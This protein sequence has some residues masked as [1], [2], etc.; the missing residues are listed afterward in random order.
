MSNGK[1]RPADAPIASRRHLLSTLGTSTVAA[2]VALAGSTVSAGPPAVKTAVTRKAAKPSFRLIAIEEHFND[3]AL[4][5]ASAQAVLPRAPYLADWGKTVDDQGEQ[6]L[7][8]PRVIKAADSLQKLFDI[9]AKRLADMNRHGIDVQVLSHAAAPQFIR[10]ENGVALIRESN[11]L[12]AQSVRPNNQRFAA[13]ASLPWQD[14]NAAVAE[15]DR[16]AALG[17][18][19]V[20]INGRPGGDFL[21]HPRYRPV[22]ARLDALKLP[23]FIHPGIPLEQVREPYYAG[24]NDEVTARLSM[25]A[26]GWHNEA[27]IQVIRMMLAGILDEFPHLNL[28]SG[29]W[30]ELVPYYLERLDDSIPQAATGLQRTLQQTYRDQVHVTNSGMTN[31]AHFNF[32][33]EVVGI[34]RM[35]FSV[36]YPYLSMNGARRF[37]E[38]LPASDE[39]KSRFAFRNAERLLNLV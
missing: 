37:V 39:D 16:C 6:D 29:H 7:S 9:G 22:L 33:K 38:D 25:F 35:L 3:P 18:K 23:L 21:D 28:I 8:R 10:G 14:V 17:F 19:G 27:G 31:P 34:D 2:T 11:S 4:A 5:K 1:T 32:V 24:F 20:L 15:T 30:G 13:F 26:W 36:D 12:L